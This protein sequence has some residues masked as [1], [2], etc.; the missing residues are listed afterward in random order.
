MRVDHRHPVTHRGK[1]GSGCPCAGVSVGKKWRAE[2]R[3]SG[4]TP[5]PQRLASLRSPRHRLKNLSERRRRREAR[6]G[7]MPLRCG[8][9]PTRHAKGSKGVQKHDPAA[10]HAVAKDPPRATPPR[11]TKT[12]VCVR[13]SQSLAQGSWAGRARRPAA[14]HVGRG[15]TV[16]HAGEN[17][18][19]T[20]T[21]PCTPSLSIYFRLSSRSHN[22]YLC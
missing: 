20:A 1:A 19:I 10:V 3:V 7:S 4:S 11:I 18:S 8:G 9:P 21:P 17:N 6:C 22:T 5:A 16:V 2:G 12:S 13:A 15:K 14:R